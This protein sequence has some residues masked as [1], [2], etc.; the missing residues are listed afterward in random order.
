MDPIA[1]RL[2]NPAP[3][4]T[5]SC[6]ELT[7]T[8]LPDG[9]TTMNARAWLPAASEEFWRG[10]G[11]YLAD[12]CFVGSVGGLLVEHGTRAMLIDAGFGPLVYRTGVGILRGGAL[13]DSLAR[14][15]RTPAEVESV[16]LTHL[17]AD[18]FGWLWRAAPGQPRPPFT[19]ARVFVGAQEWRQRALAAMSGTRPEMLAMFERQVSPV[20]EGDEIFPGVR[21]L[22]LPG[23]TVGHTGYVLESHGQRLIA[24][25][26]ALHSSLQI[27]HPELS[28]VA[29]LD[30]MRSADVR[31]GLVEQLAAPGT[32]GY[33]CHFADVQFGNAVPNGGGRVWQPRRFTP[34]PAR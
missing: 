6:G 14:A 18:H 7:V 31:H 8:Y 26:D 9:L 11:E 20:E 23:H 21:A 4:R 15:G 10:H 13:L 34:V 12:D 19:H 29:D 3:I 2:T 33:G 32:L 22:A 27:A 28:A 25:G 1:E 30:P 16:A 24:F 17:H 5:V